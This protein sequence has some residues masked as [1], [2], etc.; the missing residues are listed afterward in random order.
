MSTH[1]THSQGDQTISQ[2]SSG[3]QGYLLWRVDGTYD[4]YM[5]LDQFGTL[6]IDWSNGKDRVWISRSSIPL[7]MDV[8]V[9][10][11]IEPF[12]TL[13]SLQKRWTEV[14]GQTRVP[15]VTEPGAHSWRSGTRCD[16]GGGG[17]LCLSKEFKT[18]MYRDH[19]LVNELLA[20]SGWYGKE[21]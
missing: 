14:T 6:L 8:P 10:L 21:R 17:G 4:P 5:W 9:D 1:H 11:P 13:A 19:Q 15:F 3:T 2:S 18:R 7:R 16:V 20:E 12:D